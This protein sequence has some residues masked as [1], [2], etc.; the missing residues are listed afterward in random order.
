MNDENLTQWPHEDEKK[1]QVVPYFNEG[2]GKQSVH[3]RAGLQ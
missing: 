1:D 3:Q 2:E